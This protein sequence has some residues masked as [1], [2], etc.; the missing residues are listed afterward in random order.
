M[1]EDVAINT[2]APLPYAKPLPQITAEAKPFWDAARDHKLLIQRSV[3][4]GKYVFY[5]RA[6]S[7]YGPNDELVWVE[8]SG[9]GTIYSYTIARRPTAPQWAGEPPLIIA[10]VQL[11]EGVRMTTNIVGYAPEE[12]R[13]GMAVHVVFD[14]VTPEVTL[15]KF[16]PPPPPP[17]PVVEPEPEPE[18]IVEPETPP[19]AEVEPVAMEAEASIEELPPSPNVDVEP[20]PEAI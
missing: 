8:A 18:A 12:I 19:A 1:S 5:P 13:I 14:D 2:P 10:I 15:V 20:I 4:K 17:P 11:A 16:G 9:K 6:I 3:R 7:P